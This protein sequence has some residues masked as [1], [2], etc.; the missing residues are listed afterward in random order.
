M[1]LHVS[2]CCYVILLMRTFI[3]EAAVCQILLLLLVCEA[4][5]V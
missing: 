3:L 2:D 4:I 1:C 5:C